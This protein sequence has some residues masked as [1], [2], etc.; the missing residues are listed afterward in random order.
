MKKLGMTMTDKAIIKKKLR[1]KRQC[2]RKR[3]DTLLIS[4]TTILRILRLEWV[5]ILKLNTN[6]KNKR[7]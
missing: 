4:Q 3:K 6:L 2:K 7:N 1:R 5:G